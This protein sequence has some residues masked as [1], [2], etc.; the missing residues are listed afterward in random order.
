M[1]APTKLQHLLT[2]DITLKPDYSR[3]ALMTDFARAT[4]DDRYL[5]PG[6]TSPQDAFMRAALAWSDNVEMAERIYGYVTRDWFMFATPVLS[7]APVR[8]AFK[9]D[10]E[11][12]FQADCFMPKWRGLPISCFLNHVDDSVSGLTSHQEENGILSSKGGG[13]GGYW[14]A[15]RSGGMKTSNGSSSLG[16]IPHIKHTD[17]GMMAYSQ[18][19]TRRGS[20]AAY[21]DIS[22]P[23]IV[24]FLEIRKPTGGDINRKA[25]N[26]HHGI[27]IPDAFMEIVERC[28]QDPAASDAWDLIDPH[29]QKAVQTVSAKDLWQRVL[30][31]RM[32]TGE[33]FLHFIDT[34][35]RYLPQTQKDQGLRVNHSNLCTEIT[36]ATSPTRTA[37]CCLSS[38]NAEKFDEWEDHPLFIADLIRMLDN[39]LTFFIANAGALKDEDLQQLRE[40]VAQFVESL[41]LQLDA[42]ARGKLEQS[43]VEREAQ[44]YRNG[45]RRAVYSASQERSVGLG[46]MGFHSYL[47]SKMLPFDDFQ[48]TLAN[49]RIFSHLQRKSLEATRQLA[50]ERGEC[51]DARGTGVRNM[52]RLAV[53]PNGTS[54]II[55]NGTSP[56]TEPFRA[57][58]FSH[59]TQSGTWLVKNRHLA[60]VLEGYGMNSDEIWSHIITNRGSVQDLA[61]LSEVER[62]VFR[63]AMEIDQMWIIEHAAHRTPFICQGSSNNLFMPADVEVSYLHHVHFQAWKKGL[64]SLYYLRSEAIRR[65]DAVSR[66]VSRA[67]IAAGEPVCL[68]CEG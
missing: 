68:S 41:Q 61:F 21:L 48:A 6:E 15:I 4:L 60:A 57:N 65:A 29:T 1:N 50:V 58:A 11:A 31:L 19:D 52:H 28:T 63:T 22:H 36:Q 37:V 62:A 42:D 26:L 25:L 9:E 43:M 56:S 23:E 59:K 46:L 51:P 7:N 10:H 55:C 66:K 54:S 67:D 34:S 30:D 2:A 45:M 38:T 64:K 8:L 49:R 3:D 39:V 5:L 17:S 12:N 13:I 35:N 53:A 14:G 16:I 27:N 47:Q 18:G 32:Q 44:K 40:D 24:E 20:Y 33:P